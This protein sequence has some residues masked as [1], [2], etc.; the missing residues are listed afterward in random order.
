MDVQ[1]ACEILAKATNHQQHLRYFK[2]LYTHFGHKPSSDIKELLDF[3]CNDTLKWLQSL[4]PNARS[5]DTCI[6]YKSPIYILLDNS[7]VQELYGNDYCNKVHKNVKD[8]FQKHLNAVLASRKQTE[9]TKPQDTEPVQ[10]TTD[11]VANEKVDDASD[12]IFDCDDE[13]EDDDS[14]LDISLL[15]PANRIDKEENTIDYKM[16]YENLLFKHN[17]IVGQLKKENERLWDLACKFASK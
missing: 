13:D 9:D 1:A 16:M 12:H 17:V 5:K 14:Q 8:C 3:I 2:E 6:K 15:E 4:P 11:A 7:N 10:K